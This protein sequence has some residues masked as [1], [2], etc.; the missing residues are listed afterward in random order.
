MGGSVENR[1]HFPLAVVDAVCAVHE[2]HRRPDFIISYRFSPEEGGERGITMT[3]T[4]A[5]VDA[6]TAKPLQYLHISLWDFYNPVRRGADTEQ[7]HIAAIHQKLAGRLPL[8]GVGNLTTA[9]KVQAAYD[10]G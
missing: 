2:Q 7:T 4:F 3:D 8:I 1:L 10:T 9:E 5:L 6:L